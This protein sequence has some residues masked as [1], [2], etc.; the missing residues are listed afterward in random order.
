MK[1]QACLQLLEMFR[2]LKKNCSIILKERLYSTNARLKYDHGYDRRIKRK[3][4]EYRQFIQVL[5]TREDQLRIQE[6]SD[7]KSFKL[8]ENNIE[9]LSNEILKNET[10]EDDDFK[11]IPKLNKMIQIV[12]RQNDDDNLNRFNTVTENFNREINAY[13]DACLSNTSL[14]NESFDAI[15]LLS[16]KS[17]KSKH[18]KLADVEIFNKIYF[19]LATRK[20]TN[21][22]GYYFKLMRSNNIQPN[23]HSYAACLLSINP[24]YYKSKFIVARVL[25][26]ISNAVSLQQIKNQ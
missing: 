22:I 4:N 14:I 1:S 7:K 10:E 8:E 24:N 6:V 21:D 5:K 18:K 16:T 20:K 17:Q 15:K 12:K 11:L 23:I 3:T 19:H 13:I 2:H 25:N 9:N 26:D